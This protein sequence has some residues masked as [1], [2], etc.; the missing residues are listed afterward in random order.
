MKR[1]ANCHW[2]SHQT[3]EENWRA[4]LI[5]VLHVSPR[6]KSGPSK[7]DI[8]MDS[9]ILST[10]LSTVWV[11]T[12]RGILSPWLVL[13]AFGDS[14][15]FLRVTGRSFPQCCHPPWYCAPSYSEISNLEIFTWGP[16]VLT[17]I[18][19]SQAQKRLQKIRFGKNATNPITDFKEFILLPKLAEL[20]QFTYR[21]LKMH[22]SMQKSAFCLC[23]RSRL[24]SGTQFCL[25]DLY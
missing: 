3:L 12:G 5:N 9:A 6:T 24:R 16:W 4:K 18:S 11:T 7:W 10:E 8:C 1:Q 2:I 23:R 15:R 17:Q 20:E 21:N 22:E 25:D 13:D 14:Q 19:L